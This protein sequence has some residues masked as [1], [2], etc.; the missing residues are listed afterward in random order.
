MSLSEGGR[1]DHLRSRGFDAIPLC[2]IKLLEKSGMVA[3]IGG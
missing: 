1:D 2:S 3:A